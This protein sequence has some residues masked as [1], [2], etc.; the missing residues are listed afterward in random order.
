M[1]ARELFRTPAG[2]KRRD[3]FT[4]LETELDQLA[5]DFDELVKQ[6]DDEARTKTSQLELPLKSPRKTKN[7]QVVGV[8][9]HP[10]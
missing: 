8:V 9:Q 1:R 3:K 7:E 5:M 4:D 10:R 6:G 2:N